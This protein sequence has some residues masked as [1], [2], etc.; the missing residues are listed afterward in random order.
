MYNVHMHRNPETLTTLGSSDT[1][2][3]LHSWLLS[4]QHEERERHKQ[5]LLSW[6][7]HLTPP[8]AAHLVDPNGLA[9]PRL[10]NQ[11]ALPRSESQL[12]SSSFKSQ[13]TA[14]FQK[15]PKILSSSLPGMTAF[16]SLVH[17]LSGIF[18]M[19][20]VIVTSFPRE[21]EHLRSMFA[22]TRALSRPS[23]SLTKPKDK[24]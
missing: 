24:I 8:R 14:F 3:L 19:T 10:E 5:F 22:P 12:A 15:S 23:L 4:F 17:F 21:R 7:F 6:L 1:K 16:T 20:S 18:I 13:L 9:S 11:L 2:L